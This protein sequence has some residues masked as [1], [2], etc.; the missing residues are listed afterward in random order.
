M[1]YDTRAQFHQYN[2][3]IT[4]DT[5]ETASRRNISQYSISHFSNTKFEKDVMSPPRVYNYCME[6]KV[7]ACDLYRTIKTRHFS[8]WDIHVYIPAANMN[9]GG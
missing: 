1:H 8:S 9:G 5:L 3:Y 4:Y 6:N 7:H 2:M